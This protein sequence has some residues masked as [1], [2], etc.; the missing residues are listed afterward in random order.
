MLDDGLT[1]FG[2]LAVA[3]GLA[4]QVDH[5][6]AGFHALHRG[7]GHQPGGRPAGDQGGGDDHVEPLDRVFQGLLLL[8]PLRLG[9]FA[10]VA[11]LTGG[12]DPQ[13]EPL[14]TDRADLVGDLG[15]HVVAGGPAAEPLRRRQG[16]QAGDTDP[17]DQHRGRFDGA[18]G[19]GEH[20][21]EPGRLRR[22]EQHRLVAGDVRL[23]RQCV[24]HLG[25]GDPRDRLD[26]ERLHPGR[27]QR[28]HLIVLIAGGEEPDQRLPGMEPAH[29]LVRRRRDLHDHIRRP[30]IPDRRPDVLIG[31][32]R[33]QRAQSGTRLD[34]HVDALGDQRRHD[35]RHQRHATLTVVRFPNDTDRRARGGRALRFF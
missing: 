2:E 34:H 10:G 8:R 14:G 17:E 31:S 5:H 6:T 28:G 15:A 21:E 26:R 32:V 35:L 22:R 3:A 30:R 27:L 18:G 25:A 7:G 20:R 33:N 11:A 19:G 1:G 29:F 23:R 24:H 12:V 16:L 9:E 4:G 13:I